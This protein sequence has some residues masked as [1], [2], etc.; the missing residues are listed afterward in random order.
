M[1]KLS[2]GSVG[3]RGAKGTPSNEFRPFGIGWTRFVLPMCPSACRLF[4][5]LQVDYL[6]VSSLLV[7]ES[8]I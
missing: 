8:L 5:V 7:S 4:D 2:V 1:R 3:A 6:R